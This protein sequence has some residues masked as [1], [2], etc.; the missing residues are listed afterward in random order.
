M[1]FKYAARTKETTSNQPAVGAG[2]VLAGNRPGCKTAVAGIGDGNSSAWCAQKVDANGNASG[3]WEEFVGTVTAGAPNTLSRDHLID[4]STGDWI[5]WSVTGENA[6]PDVY[7]T[8]PAGNEAGDIIAPLFG[9]GQTWYV[10]QS[11]PVGILAAGFFSNVTWLFPFQLRR[12]ALLTGYRINVTGA[13]GGANGNLR[14]GTYT[15]AN[16][17]PKALVAGSTA[18]LSLAAT[19]I[20]K[21]AGLNAFLPPGTYWLAAQSG[22]GLGKLAGQPSGQEQQIAGYS[23]WGSLDSDG[24][25]NNPAIGATCSTVNYAGGLPDPWVGA[26]NRNPGGG[27]FLPCVQFAIADL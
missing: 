17:A 5:D 19:G 22:S 14:A 10:P 20:V 4:S 13:D 8:A 12:P 3:A 21:A 11:F 16:G 24:V 25:F 23:M 1:A 9:D 6:S 2:F 15:D 27:T 18:V 26:L 7:V